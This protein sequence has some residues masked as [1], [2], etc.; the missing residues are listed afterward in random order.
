MESLIFLRRDPETY[1]PAL[2]LNRYEQKNMFTPPQAVNLRRGTPIWSLLTDAGIRSTV[3]RC[4][5]TFPPDEIRGRILAGVGVPDLRGGLGTSTFYSSTDDL[6][7]QESEKVVHVRA[8]GKNKITTYVN[9]PRNPKS[10]ADFQ[11]DITIHVEPESRRIKIHSKGQPKELVVREGEWSDWLRVQFKLGLLQSVWGIVR[12]HLVQIAPEFELYASPVNFDPAAPMFP[13]SS[14]PEYAG[15]LVE[16]LGT[17]YTTGMAEDH[18]GLNNERFDELAYLEQCTL[19]LRER[20]KMMLY[21]LERFRQGLFFCLFDTP[22][23]L[24]HMFWRFRENS[25]P[26]NH[27]NVVPEMKYMI[28][29]HYRTCLV[30]I[31]QNIFG[32]I[33]KNKEESVRQISDSNMQTSGMSRRQFLLGTGVSVAALAVSVQGQ[34]IWAENRQLARI[35][36]PSQRTP[37][38]LLLILDTVR[39]ESLSLHGHI[40]QTTPKL[41][42]FANRSV[43]FDRAI[44][45]APWTLPSHSS[46]FTRRWHH[47]VSSDWLLPLDHSHPTLAEVLTAHGYHTAGFVANLSYCGRETGVNRG[48]LHYEDYPVSIGQVAI[49]S[50]LGQTVVSSDRLRRAIGYHELVNRKTAAMINNDFLKWLSGRDTEHPFFAFLNYFD[51]H[52]PYLPPPPFDTMFGDPN[53]VR[54]NFQHSAFDAVRDKRGLSPQDIQAEIGAYEGTIAYL[55]DQIDLLIKELERRNIL[56]D[57]IVIIA[58]DHGEEFGEHG[59]FEHGNTLYLPSIHV[60]LMISYPAHIPSGVRVNEPVSLRN[61][62]ATLIDVIGIESAVDFPGYS[63]RRHWKGENDTDD[64]RGEPVL[65]EVNV[66]G[67]DPNAARNLKSLV[68]EKYHYIRYADGQEELFDFDAD[69]LETEDLVDSGEGHQMLDRFRIA[70]DEARNQKPG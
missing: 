30:K 15:H 25:H 63:L 20:E 7:S 43:I 38:I 26:A 34:A 49:S 2:A 8:E 48:F 16:K 5:C 18:D 29:E 14:P 3:L 17:F 51:A 32:S 52:E 37:N 13:I 45:T 19:V 9:G 11:F 21:E 55:D 44:A 53:I 23:R 50:S 33:I 6:K 46:M 54:N 58:S 67:W 60:P 68:M 31:R 39:A 64:W 28:E 65:A 66:E 42:Q 12:F 69:P 61:L 22:D 27:G 41:E 62:P 35:A 59:E 1:L 36:L 10:K 4:P 24:Q 70:L 47:E 57:T 40:R 56:D